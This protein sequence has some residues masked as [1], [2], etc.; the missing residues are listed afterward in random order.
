[1]REFLVN[2]GY[3]KKRI[4]NFLFDMLPNVNASVIYKA[5]RKRNIKVNNKRVS[6]SYLLSVKDKVQIYIPDHYLDQCPDDNKPD[7]IEPEIVYEDNY[8]V[9]VSKPQGMAVHKDKNEEVVVLDNWLQSFF[10]ARETMLYEE[11]FPS[12]CHRLDRNTGG[13]VL[14]AKD[15]K[16]L[17]ILED[18]FRMHEIGKKYLC[19]VN[20]VPAKKSQELHHYLRKDSKKSRVFIFDNP[21]KGSEPITTRYR[22]LKKVD[23][24]SLLEVELVTGK[25]HQIRA[26]LAYIGHPLLGD[27]KYGINAV[28]KALKLKWQALWAKEITFKFNNPS[29]H[30]E[31]LKGKTVLLPKIHWEGQ[32]KDMAD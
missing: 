23:E 11:G 18:K 24:F 13:L 5:F 1:M 12:L 25:T 20:G 16:T 31:Y 22:V 7:T 21:V 2:A 14:F 29:G 26:H 27:G 17:A 10:R 6:M 4:D 30:L 28:N 9:V 8:I 19:M 15:S 3:D 32:L